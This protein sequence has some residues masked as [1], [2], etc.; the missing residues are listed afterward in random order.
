MQMIKTVISSGVWTLFEQKKKIRDVYVG[1][2]KY[3]LSMH[4]Y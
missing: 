1:M 2:D 4:T 3:T